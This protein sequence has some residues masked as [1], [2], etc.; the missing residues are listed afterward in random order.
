MAKVTKVDI[1][2]SFPIET[3]D[4]GD[5]LIE[6]LRAQRN[7]EKNKIQSRN[8]SFTENSKE[9]TVGIGSRENEDFSRIYI[10]NNENDIQNNENDIQKNKTNKKLDSNA[11]IEQQFETLIIVNS[12]YEIK[13]ESITKL[14]KYIVYSISTYTI[15]LM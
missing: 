13:K 4:P 6:F 12:E 15:H 5:T 11:K 3:N 1:K 7:L 2:A 10:P 9:A 8:W 14:N